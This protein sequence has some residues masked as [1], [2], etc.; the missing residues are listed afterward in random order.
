MGN[1]SKSMILFHAV[2][3]FI[4]L[5]TPA[6]PA[7]PSVL[8]V[9]LEDWRLVS[10]HVTELATFA[11]GSRGE[12]HGRW[13]SASY[14]RPAPPAGIEVHLTEGRGTGRFFVP[15]GMVSSDDGPIGFSTTYETLD[16]DGKRAVLERNNVM[17][18][19]L[20]VALD[21]YLTVTFETRGVSRE[22]LI[23]FAAFMIEAMNT[24]GR[25]PPLQ[26]H[27]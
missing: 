9:E 22:E 6:L 12:D 7:C 23:G 27:E 11:D 18:S 2:V 13:I 21:V 10:E 19:A 5:I 4:F 1:F 8:P 26:Y 24:G 15:E 14:V 25:T 3:I 17:G 16:I 20:A